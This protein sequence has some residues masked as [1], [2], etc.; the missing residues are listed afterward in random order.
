MIYASYKDYHEPLDAFVSVVFDKSKTCYHSLNI[1]DQ[2]VQLVSSSKL[3]FDVLLPA[4]AHLSYDE[5]AADPEFTLYL[6]D[7]SQLP[8]SAAQLPAIHWK[9][10]I[11][12][13]HRGVLV[14]GLYMQFVHIESTGVRILSAFDEHTKEA[15]YIVSDAEKLPWYISGAPMHEI[16][17][18]WTRSIGMHILHGGVIGD[19]QNGIALLG[20]KGAGKSTMVLTCLENGF[21]YISE[22]YCIVTNDDQPIAY[23]LYNSAKFTNYTFERFPHLASYKK[24]N[25]SAGE[26]YLVYYN[27]IY[28]DKMLYKLPLMA[29]IS[30][31]LQKEL[32]SSLSHLDVNRSFLDMIASTT[33][34]NPT[35]EL[36][37]ADFFQCL[38]SKIPAYELT[39]G[40]DQ[41]KT[42]TLL[43]DLVKEK[44]TNLA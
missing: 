39:F 28:P 13:G 37:S 35:Y 2:R 42:Q 33:L 15:Y 38:K 24:N 43:S 8:G 4:I 1:A 19:Q 32:P 6:I 22:D 21:H 7:L 41:R 16:L 17:Y 27:D 12:R 26:K 29:F 40:S 20:A 30:L 36:T 9:P 18:W 14:D 25:G 31:N 23:S 3:L 10:L 11:R 34:Q 44:E 5:V